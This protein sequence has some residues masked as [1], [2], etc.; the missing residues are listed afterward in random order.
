MLGRPGGLGKH[1]RR[2]SAA[3]AAALTLEEAIA[4]VPNVTL[5]LQNSGLSVTNGAVVAWANQGSAGGTTSG[6]SGNNTWETNSIN[7]FPAAL[8]DASGEGMT[9]SGVTGSSLLGS[10]FEATWFFAERR[11]GNQGASSSPFGNNVIFGDASGH[12]RINFAQNSRRLFFGFFNPSH[13][14]FDTGIVVPD[15]V[16]Y[17]CAIR[18]KADGSLRVNLNGVVTT[19]PANTMLGATT[20]YQGVAPWI[21]YNQGGGASRGHFY[22]ISSDPVSDTIMDNMVDAMKASPQLYG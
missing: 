7:G 5:R 16:P 20:A 4:A 8:A 3:G 17:V 21:N 1:S 2:R 18:F 12:Y 6:A 19:F 11:T 10:T 22:M 14:G 9:L 13:T 15:A